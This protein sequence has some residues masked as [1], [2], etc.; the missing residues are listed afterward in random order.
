MGLAEI[1]K[2]RIICII[3]SYFSNYLTASM[4]SMSELALLTT[5]SE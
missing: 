2:I 4:Q 3:Y 5:N 1:N